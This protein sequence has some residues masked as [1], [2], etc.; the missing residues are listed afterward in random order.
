MAIHVYRI[1]IGKKVKEYREKNGLSQNVFGKI[2]GVSPQAVCK[3]E[4][5]MSYPD[6]I[7]LPE[8]AKILECTI[9]DFFTL[10]V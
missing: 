10:E 2:I 8:L 6:I 1:T 3:W 4:L 5:G 7:I 9:D